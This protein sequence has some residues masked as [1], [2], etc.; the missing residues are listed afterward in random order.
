MGENT[1]SNLSV[2]R[3]Y[4]VPS[5]ITIPWFE[6][7]V[8][9]IQSFCNPITSFSGEC[10]LQTNYQDR[11][12][13]G[14]LEDWAEY[15]RHYWTEMASSWAWFY[16]DKLTL[17]FRCDYERSAIELEIRGLALEEGNLILAQLEENLQLA[18]VG[19]G[20]A[21]EYSVKQRF[22]APSPLIKW[23]EQF[24]NYANSSWTTR[25]DFHGSYV[26]RNYFYGT[27]VRLEAV[28][29]WVSAIH[30]N[31]LE[32]VESVA[33]F[34]S[35]NR[36]IS[37][38]CDHQRSLVELEVREPSLEASNG[39]MAEMAKHLNLKQIEDDP[40]RY[41][42]SAATYK[43]T[44][45]DKQR[46]IDSTRVLLKECFEGQEPITREAYVTKVLDDNIE[47]LQGFHNINAYLKFLEESNDSAYEWTGLL[48]EGTN[49]LA[50]GM[51]LNKKDKR[52]EFR[53]SIPPNELEDK[54]VKHYK[55]PLQLKLTKGGSAGSAISSETQPKAEKWWVK[56]AMQIVVVFVTI[57]AL[58]FALS[59]LRATQTDYD[60]KITNPILSP[61]QV[62]TAE[63]PL[64]W[65]LWPKDSFLYGP[66]YHAPASILIMHKGVTVDQLDSIVPPYTLSLKEGEGEYIV[67]VRPNKKAQPT[68]IVVTYTNPSDVKTT[69]F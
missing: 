33:R 54:V 24:I 66:D 47:R 19:S 17:A 4:L 10:T 12:S 27:E 50:V 31:W 32:V 40:Y 3:K 42:K 15:L 13:I 69:P 61:A 34:R 28:Q 62:N 51:T 65:Y 48:I 21:N 18:P 43:V 38:R 41:R 1:T 68:R 36:E 23:L 11:V 29:E 8:A 59:L 9:Q 7:A 63:V 5:P 14:S 6:K 37:L 52:L 60:L 45:W 22:F 25:T 44:D 53:S 56:Y 2:G 67:E 57:L 16:S 46:Y 55:E 64:D 20:V 35:N 39:V 26:L 58:P 49:G 30:Q